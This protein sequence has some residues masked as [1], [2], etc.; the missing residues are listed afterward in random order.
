MIQAGD[1][2]APGMPRSRDPAPASS[3]R[4]GGGKG[5]IKACH[6]SHMT[7]Y[8]AI[9]LALLPWSPASADHYEVYIL[10]GQSNAGG[11]GYVSREFSQFSP[12]GDDGL[13]ELGKSSYLVPQPDTLFI[14]WRGGTPNAGRPVLWEARSD[15][16]IPLKAGYSLY[17]YN[18]SSPELLGAETVNH[19]FGAEITSPNE[20]AKAGPAGKSRSSSIR[21]AT[22]LSAPRQP[23][24]PGIPPRAGPTTS[25]RWPMRGIATVDCSIW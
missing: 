25:P 15:G 1:V 2:A 11:H 8:R 17:G 24:V 18:S 9:I 19:P 5:H 13:L 12:Q 21:K 10:A 22:P 16:W 6:R 23:R 3:R 7:S 20:S 4:S 14:H